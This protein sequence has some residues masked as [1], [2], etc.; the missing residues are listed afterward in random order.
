[1]FCFIFS[2]RLVD[3]L[4]I[5]FYIL[6]PNQDL[7]EMEARLIKFFEKRIPEWNGLKGVS[8]SQDEFSQ[9][10]TQNNIFV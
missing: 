8:P 7:K 3:R 4:D 6:N 9:A 5:G 1:M 2:F 10:L